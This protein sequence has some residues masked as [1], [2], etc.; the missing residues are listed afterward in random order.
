MRVSKVDAARPEQPGLEREANLP[1]TDSSTPLNQG[2][3]RSMLHKPYFN[4]ATLIIAVL[5]LC[6][7]CLLGIV[8]VLVSRGTAND[9]QFAKWLLEIPLLVMLSGLFGIGAFQVASHHQG[10]L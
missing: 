1:T 6:I 2:D 5:G 9:F 7:L 8:L 10:K 3:S 4:S